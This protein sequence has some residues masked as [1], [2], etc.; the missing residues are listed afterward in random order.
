MPDIKPLNVVLFETASKGLHI[1]YIGRYIDISRYCD[2]TVHID[3]L[4]FFFVISTLFAIMVEAV[5]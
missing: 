1:Q 3:D 5:E 2:M 4:G